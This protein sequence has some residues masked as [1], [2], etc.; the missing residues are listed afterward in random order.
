MCTV[1]WLLRPDG[2]ELF[3]N[4]DELRR[5]ARA[6]GPRLHVRAGVRY[7]A[8][9][10]GE[11]GGT[12][13]AVNE[14]GLSLCLLNRYHHRTA[15]RPPR[16]TS[17]GAL[18]TGLADSAGV[19]DALTR[20]ADRDLA[21]YRPFTLLVLGPEGLARVAVWDG[22]HL[23]APRDAA[24]PLAS[25]GHDPEGIGTIRRR[26]WDAEVGV[27]GAPTT[28]RLLAFHRSHQPSRSALSPCMHRDDARTVSFSHV[29]V[30]SA[31][32]SIAYADGPPCCTALEAPVTCARRLLAAVG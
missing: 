26:L 13:L 16:Y 9:V 18:V 10:D 7:L 14:L 31:E 27:W 3:C 20:L 29:R 11:A 15:P 8:P 30:D 17:R 24:P 19:A 6:L 25:S 4:R 32:V 21:A 5:R 12:W 22:G 28:A 1:S 23:A 2:Y